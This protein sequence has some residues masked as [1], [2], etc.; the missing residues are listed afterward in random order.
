MIVSDI[1]NNSLRGTLDDIAEA[2]FGDTELFGFLADGVRFIQ[3]N[4]P[5]SRV[6]R[7]GGMNSVLLGTFANGGVEVPLDPMYQEPLREYVLWR[8][9]SAD[10]GDAADARR[11]ANHEASMLAWFTGAAMQGRGG[12]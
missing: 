7:D 9:F 12:R 1:I 4:H 5:R 11:A 6:K 10:K 3:I 2:K 8:C